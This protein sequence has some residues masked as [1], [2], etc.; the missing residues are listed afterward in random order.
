MDVSE[1]FDQV[2]YLSF[3]NKLPIMEG[4]RL[5]FEKKMC[6]LTVC[7]NHHIAM[8]KKLEDNI[9]T[10][11]DMHAL[12][13]GIIPL[14]ATIEGATHSQY[15]DINGVIHIRRIGEEPYFFDIANFRILK[16]PSA[17]QFIPALETPFEPLIDEYLKH[18]RRPKL[19]LPRNY[20]Y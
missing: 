4:K 3:T 6:N 14:P 8:I 18:L 1:P 7:A 9:V 12:S 17:P 5:C 11:F 16:A 20:F 19:H 10:L 13:N 2:V 15:I